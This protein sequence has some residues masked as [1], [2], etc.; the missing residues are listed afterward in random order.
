M[1]N[2][3]STV[4]VY[5]EYVDSVRDGYT[6]WVEVT[7]ATYYLG[8]ITVVRLI[9]IYIQQPAESHFLRHNIYISCLTR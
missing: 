1:L 5:A 8:C 4:L 9:D 3:M 2:V 7:N 6:N